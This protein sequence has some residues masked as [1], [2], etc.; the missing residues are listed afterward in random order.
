MGKRGTKIGRPNG[1]QAEH[2]NVKFRG[3]A[4]KVNPSPNNLS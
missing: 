1:P 4:A 2:P 3:R